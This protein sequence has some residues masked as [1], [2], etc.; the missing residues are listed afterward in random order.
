[1]GTDLAAGPSQDQPLC[2]LDVPLQAWCLIL[3][4]LGTASAFREEGGREG[5][6]RTAVLSLPLGRQGP[7]QSPT[8]DF[9][10][11]LMAMLGHQAS[12]RLQ[13]RLG[14][15]EQDR[16]PPGWTAWLWGVL[17]T[18]GVLSSI[19]GLHPPDALV[20]TTNSVPRHGSGD[21]TTSGRETLA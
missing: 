8:R 7:S 11:G 19:T 10:P 12:P 6:G 4:Q 9:L 1:M 3:P 20:V 5:G 21:K 16:R 14:A 2:D 18:V 13:A 17:C 15:Q